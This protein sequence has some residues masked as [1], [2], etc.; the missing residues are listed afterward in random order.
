MRRKASWGGVLFAMTLFNVAQ[1]QLE[2]AK[3]QA[4]VEHQ[5]NVTFAK[6]GDREVALDLFVPKDGGARHP[7]IVCIHGGGWVKGDRSLMTPLARALAERGFVAAAISYR[8]SGEKKFPAAIEDCKAAVRW[9]RTHA[10]EYGIDPQAIGATGLSAG[11]HLAALLATSGGESE[12]EGDGGNREQS[13]RIQAAVAMGAQ[14]DL[15][16]PRIAEWSRK[17]DEPYYRTFLGG[18]FDDVPKV[19]AAASPRHYLNTGDPP[20]MFIT[21]EL[22]HPTSHADDMRGD[23]MRL[24]IPTGLTIIPQ[25]PHSFLNNEVW[26]NAAVDAMASFFDLHLR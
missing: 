22:D 10:D 2:P 17:P 1:A 20:L 14:S 4:E 18:S 11:G 7:A 6:Y 25:A 12:L 23:L 3:R 21:G 13:S 19:Y 15:E 8:L 16:S 5:A 24:G 26:L 9:L